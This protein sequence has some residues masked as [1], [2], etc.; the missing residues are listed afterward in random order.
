MLTGMLKTVYSNKLRLRVCVCV[1]GGGGGGGIMTKHASISHIQA[2]FIVRADQVGLNLT[3]S[4]TPKLGFLT[5]WPCV[6]VVLYC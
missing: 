3:L 4:E 5:S 1:G 2:C 6:V